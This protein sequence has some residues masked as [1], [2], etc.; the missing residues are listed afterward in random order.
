[1]FLTIEIVDN[2]NEAKIFGQNFQ[3]EFFVE[4]ELHLF[5]MHHNAQAIAQPHSYMRQVE[6]YFRIL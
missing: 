4:H 6:N 5:E 3:L 2:V 1:M